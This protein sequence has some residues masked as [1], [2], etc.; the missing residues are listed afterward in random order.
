MP[1]TTTTFPTSWSFVPTT[2]ERPDNNSTGKPATSRIELSAS[3]HGTTML[4]AKRTGTKPTSMVVPWVD[5]DNSMRLV[6]I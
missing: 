2:T 5:A 3:I 6:A 1:T 4:N